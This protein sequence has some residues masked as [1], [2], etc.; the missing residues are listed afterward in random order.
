MSSSGME[1]H[2]VQRM[3][4]GKQQKVSRQGSIEEQSYARHAA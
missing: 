1:L 3:V 4:E 2:R